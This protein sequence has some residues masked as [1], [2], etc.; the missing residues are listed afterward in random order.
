MAAQA[1]YRQLQVKSLEQEQPLAF[2]RSAE[3][4]AEISALWRLVQRGT[5]AGSC[6]L[7]THQPF[8]GTHSQRLTFV[9]GEGE[10]GLENQGLNR[11]GMH[12]VGGQLYEGVLWARAEQTTEVWVALESSDGARVHAEQRLAVAAGD[13]QRLEFT[14]T[15]SAT[16][17]KGR[18]AVTLRKPGSVVLGYVFLQPRPKVVSQI[19]LC[20]GMWP[21]HCRIKASRC[22]ATAVR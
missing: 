1:R 17:A 19:C 12:F 10:L 8:L 14:L 4:N 7:E 15:P 2:E 5:A 21:K 22:S 16:Q 20:V 11:W 3:E 6:S 13:W 9:S 18:L